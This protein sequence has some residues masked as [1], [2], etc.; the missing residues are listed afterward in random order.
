MIYKAKHFRLTKFSK[1]SPHIPED[2]ASGVQVG[3]IETGNCLICYKYDIIIRL[4]TFY[5]FL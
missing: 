1:N 3:D 2:I 4:M 5:K